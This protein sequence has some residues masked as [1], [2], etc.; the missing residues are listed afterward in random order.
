MDSQILNITED[1]LK[2][3]AKAKAFF[4]EEYQEKMR[5]YINM[6]WA[7]KIKFNL[8]AVMDSVLELC[9]FKSIREN[10]T[11]LLLLMAAAVEITQESKSGT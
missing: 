4:K 7:H 10:E 9:S 5:P 3:Q 2:C 6:I 8:P 11:A 1:M